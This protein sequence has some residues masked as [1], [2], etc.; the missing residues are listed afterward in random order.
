[1]KDY[2]LKTGIKKARKARKLTQKEFADLMDVH[3]KTVMNWEQGLAKPSIDMLVQIA[4]VLRC[5]MDCLFDRMDYRTH[6]NQWIHEKTG[7]SEDAAE[8]LCL[9]NESDDP[10]YK[11]FYLQSLEC[12]DLL[13]RSDTTLLSDILEFMD[14]DQVMI[15]NDDPEL[16]PGMD[17]FDPAQLPDRQ[18]KNP[19]MNNTRSGISRYIS[20]EEL[21]DLIRESLKTKIFDGLRLLALKKRNQ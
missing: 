11:P 19:T 2:S 6:D 16:Y 10:L 3:V 13:I 21:Q 14:A 5:D 18:V 1:M 17:P 15:T 20:P 8:L 9:M 4:D 12:I 7:L